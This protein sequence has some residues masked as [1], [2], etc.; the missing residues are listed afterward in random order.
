VPGIRVGHYTDEEGITGCT[1]VLCQEG[2]VAGVDVRGSAPGTRETDL[3]HPGNL[4]QKVQAVLLSG[5][6]AF[7]LEAAGGV[8]R[9]LEERGHGFDVGMTRV[10]IVPAAILFDLA[11]G[12]SKVRPGLEEGYQA[13]LAATAQKPAEGSVGV[14][15]GATVGKMLGLTR[16]T[17]GGVGTT[18]QR[19]CG[20][21][22]LGALVAVNALG[23]VI[24]PALGTIIAGPRRED[25]TGFYD[26]MELLR[27]GRGVTPFPQNTTLGV[28]ATNVSLDKA[29][30]NKMAQMCHDGI[31]RA[32]YPAHT[33]FD[34]DVI[35]V[36]STGEKEEGADI[37]LLGSVGAEVVSQAIVRAVKEA[38]S[39]GGI[40]AA[41]DIKVKG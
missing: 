30:A 37:S 18:S 12:S 7:G 29:Q 4:V 36:L 26:S 41:R 10:P 11:I 39:L 1:V 19:V 38:E 13:C 6:S 33:M 40:T 22:V 16:A 24:D 23:S 20:D 27:E 5:G 9:Y 34:G 2:C 17:K 32:I 15:T 21:I 25:D 35:F 3:L 31:A 28:V 8:M 14:G